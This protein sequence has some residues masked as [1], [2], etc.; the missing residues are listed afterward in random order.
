MAI[1]VHGMRGAFAGPRLALPLRPLGTGTARR[2]P[3]V[4]ALLTGA[5]AVVEAVALLAVALH[6]LDGLL[7][8]PSRPAGP[9]V[10]VG[11]LLLA[12]WIVLA[13]GSG[14]A[15]VD[16]SG[17]RM[18]VGVAVGELALV[19][20]LGVAALLVP[21]ALPLALPGALL[22][23]VSVPVGKL[24]LAG[25]PSVAA[26]LAAGPRV[27]ERRPDPAVAHRGLATATLAVIGLAL[28]AL[29]LV[30]P[31]DDPL[32]PGDIAST[33]VTAH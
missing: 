25:S 15:V 29:A 11:L 30:G 1:D 6:G 19:A 13:A 3:P 14:A 17:R 24:L 5:L 22:L 32:G 4:T 31:V 28:G 33:T 16:G 8:G 27:V 7:G 23:A 26:W 10:A 20:L 21:V 12:A 2:R 9:V 18:L